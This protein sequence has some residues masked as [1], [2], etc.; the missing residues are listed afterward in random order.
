MDKEIIGFD[1]PTVFGEALALLF[2][3]VFGFKQRDAIIRNVNRCQHIIQHLTIGLSPSKEMMQKVV[4]ERPF[5]PFGV[6]GLTN[7]TKFDGSPGNSLAEKFPDITKG[8]YSR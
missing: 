6:D 7:T 5:A 1:R 3:S 2:F 8:W 4:S